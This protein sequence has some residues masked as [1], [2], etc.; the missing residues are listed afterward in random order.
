MHTQILK[1]QPSEFV[2]YY[3]FI[4]I[5]DESK[6]QERE[7]PCTFHFKLYKIFNTYSGL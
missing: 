6:V 5:S 3:V 2:F 7:N 1:T 4:T